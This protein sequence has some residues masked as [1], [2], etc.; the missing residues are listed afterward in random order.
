MQRAP[1]KK[2]ILNQQNRKKVV[3]AVV[4]ATRSPISCSNQSR[5]T[6]NPTPSTPTP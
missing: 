2:T 4:V 3:V 1:F 5:K 6:A